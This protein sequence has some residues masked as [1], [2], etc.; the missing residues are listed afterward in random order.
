MPDFPD[1]LETLK[2][3]RPYIIQNQ[4]KLSK[5]F[6]EHICRATNS[7]MYL[8]KIL[9]NEELSYSFTGVFNYPLE[10]P[11]I[12]CFILLFIV[13]KLLTNCIVCNKCLVSNKH[14]PPFWNK[15]TSTNQALHIHHAYYCR[16]PYTPSV[17]TDFFLDCHLL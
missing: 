17:I 6:K 8:F 15:T 4:E 2:I 12:V 3:K 16:Y 10:I 9:Q 14:V 11:A 7:Q 1:G 13:H 5:N